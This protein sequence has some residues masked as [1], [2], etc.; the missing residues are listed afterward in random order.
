MIDSIRHVSTPEGVE[1]ELRSAGVYVRGAAC[2]IDFSIYILVWLLTMLVLAIFGAFGIGVALILVFIMNWFYPVY[3]E[4]MHNGAT[5]GKRIF[6]IC[7]VMNNGTPVTWD[8]SVLRNLLRFADLLPTAYLCGIV[9]MVCDRSS[10]RL[11]DLAAGTLVVYRDDVD[12]LPEIEEVDPVMPSVS[13]HQHEQRAIIEFAERRERWA[14]KRQQ[15]LANILEPLT[16]ERDEVGA[17]RL[18]GIAT[19]LLGGR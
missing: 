6:G 8:A 3:F 12:R 18:S 11:G 14:P 9:F 15:E 2:M 13:L 17:E 19:H 4:V 1:L 10:R 7:V 16:Q 5:P